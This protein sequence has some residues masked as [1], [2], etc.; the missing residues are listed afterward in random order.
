[1]WKNTHM[2]P[3]TKLS[4]SWEPQVLF[5][6]KRQIFLKST[7]GP[8][9]PPP[10]PPGSSYR[11]RDVVGSLYEV[12]QSIPIDSRCIHDLGR[13]SSQPCI[14]VRKAA[15][16]RKTSKIANFLDFAW[17]S[18][19][20]ATGSGGN[21]ACHRSRMV[22]SMPGAVFLHIFFIQTMFFRATHW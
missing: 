7:L 20:R 17:C 15:E 5:F 6:E 8:L 3:D 19:F 11:S 22:D 16:E 18:S 4:S 14:Q 12:F 21:G 2:S 13:P 10:R 9:G 1:M